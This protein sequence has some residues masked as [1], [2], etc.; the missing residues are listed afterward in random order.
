MFKT[1]RGE[2]HKTHAVR[3]ALH[4]DVSLKLQNFSRNKENKN[5][6]WHPLSARADSLK[7]MEIKRSDFELKATSDVITCGVVE[8]KLSSFVLKMEEK[9][10]EGRRNK[11]R[12]F[13]L[14]PRRDHDGVASVELVFVKALS[15]N[16]SFMAFAAIAR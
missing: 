12:R 3:V 8:K 6:L 16:D 2:R 13:C 10:S 9:A 7:R 1:A 15:I 11:S 5:N 14:T 4:L